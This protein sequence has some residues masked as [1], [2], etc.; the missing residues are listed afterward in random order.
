MLFKDD[1]FA[2]SLWCGPYFECTDPLNKR[3]N[4]WILIYSLPLIDENM[5]LKGAVS[6]KLKLTNMDLNQCDNGDPVF[7]GTHKCKSNSECNYTPFNKFK[8]GESFEVI[9]IILVSYLTLK[10]L[11][12]KC[13]VQ[14]SFGLQI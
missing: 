5:K 1:E 14:I 6:I 13:D 7:A 10:I 9:L 11:T 2:S 12:F 3:T 8:L 4:D